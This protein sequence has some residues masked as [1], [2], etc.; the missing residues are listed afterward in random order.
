VYFSTIFALSVKNY[1]VSLNI[2]L[3]NIIIIFTI[4]TENSGRVVF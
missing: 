4:D 1:N 3:E 2:L